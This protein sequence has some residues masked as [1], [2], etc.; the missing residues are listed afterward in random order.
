MKINIIRREPSE[1]QKFFSSPLDFSQR[2][3]VKKLQL[4]GKI[5]ATM[6][7]LGLNQTKLAKKMDV[8]PSRITTLLDGTQNLTIETL[9]RAAE[10][11]ESDVEIAIVPKAQKARWVFYDED[12][13]HEV[14]K[15]KTK[16]PR[17][18]DTRFNFSGKVAPN[19]FCDAA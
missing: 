16:A 13:C 15:P 1:I 12:D 11:V 3:E 14:F 19:D 10:A 17:E 4:A 7:S 5:F 9:M 8:S 2:V 6:K 18:D